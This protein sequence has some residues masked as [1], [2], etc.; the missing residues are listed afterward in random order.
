MT[1]ADCKF[2]K[3][4]PKFGKVIEHY[5]KA[6]EHAIH[7]AREAANPQEAEEEG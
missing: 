2:A 3:T 4:K 7:A 1:K 5:E 6:W